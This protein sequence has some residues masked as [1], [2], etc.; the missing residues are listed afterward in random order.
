MNRVLEVLGKLEKI[1]EFGSC[2]P[3]LE[4]EK[5]NDEQLRAVVDAKFSGDRQQMGEAYKQYGERL[6]SPSYR[7]AVTA[8]IAS[9]S[10]GALPS[11]AH[12]V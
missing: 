1:T 11:F 4:A 7:T 10:K 3:I 12:V 8:F 5:L 9:G 6:V 2:L